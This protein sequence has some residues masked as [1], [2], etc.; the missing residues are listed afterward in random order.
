MKIDNYI[1]K[2]IEDTG[3]SKKEIYSLVEE[4]KKRVTR[5]DL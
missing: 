3:L 5:T 4:K 1:R 2:I